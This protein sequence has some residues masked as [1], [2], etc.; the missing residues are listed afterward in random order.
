MNIPDI[1]SFLKLFSVE[2]RSMS[3]KYEFS[4]KITD[5]Y[6]QIDSVICNI[7]NQLKLSGAYN[8]YHSKNNISFQNSFKERGFSLKLMSILTSGRIQINN[9]PT[10]IIII[11]ECKYLIVYDLGLIIAGSLLGFFLNS[12]FYIWILGGLFGLIIRLITVYLKSKELIRNSLL[13]CKFE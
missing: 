13:N 9:S 4:E 1:F 8:I 12:M 11:F 10:G 6:L 3:I 5:K 2:L 7:E